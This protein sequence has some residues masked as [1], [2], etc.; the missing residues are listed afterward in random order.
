MV[1]PHPTS[2]PLQDEGFVEDVNNLLNTGEIPN[3]FPAE[4]ADAVPFETG[5]HRQSFVS[6]GL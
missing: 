3:L 4:E 6:E 5:T 2:L 1:S